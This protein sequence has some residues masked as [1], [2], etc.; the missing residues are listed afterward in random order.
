MSG[1]GDYKRY[2]ELN[3]KDIA[4][5]LNNPEEIKEF[6]ALYKRKLATSRKGSISEEGLQI[7]GEGM[8]AFYD[9]VIKKHA[10]KLAKK[11]GSKV[12]IKD[13]DTGSGTEQVWPMKITPEMK[14]AMAGGVTLGG[15]AVLPGLLQE[16]NQNQ[17]PNGLLNY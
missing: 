13:V 4:G 17:Q 5:K 16:R 7:G 14:K 15:A 9:K 12:E 3:I 8:K 2:K 1:A 6:D 10:T 11:H